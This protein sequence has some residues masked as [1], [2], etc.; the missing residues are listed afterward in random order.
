LIYGQ[1]RKKYGY[2]EYDTAQLEDANL[3]RVKSG[4]ELVEASFT[5]LQTRW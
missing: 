2:E 3:Y 4:E 5:T 1:S